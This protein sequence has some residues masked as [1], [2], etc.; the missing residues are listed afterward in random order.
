L[1]KGRG[2]AGGM[3]VLNRENLSYVQKYVTNKNIV[4]PPRSGTI[5]QRYGSGAFF[6]QNFSKKLNF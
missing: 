5:S 4:G 6:A 3:L 1:T 2:G